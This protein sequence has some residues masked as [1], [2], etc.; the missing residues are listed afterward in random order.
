MRTFELWFD[1]SGRFLD[2]GHHEEDE[3][4]LVGLLFNTKAIDEDRAKAMLSRAFKDAGKEFPDRPHATSLRGDE[5]STI[6]A[7]LLPDLDGRAQPVR[8]TNEQK[9]SLG[10]RELTY[11]GFMRELVARVADS[12]LEEH[13]PV[14]L[15]VFPARLML[16][17]GAPDV[18]HQLSEKDYRRQLISEMKTQIAR[19][20][21]ADKGL[22]LKVELKSART[23]PILWLADFLSNASFRDFRKL[24]A[25]VSE[26]LKRAFGRWDLTFS[27]RPLLKR[28]DDL[29]RDHS[30]G[31]AVVESLTALE[32]PAIGKALKG[33]VAKK[34]DACAQALCALPIP[35]RQAHFLALNS[36]LTTLVSVER[37]LDIAG[38]ALRQ[39]EEHVIAPMRASSPVRQMHFIHRQEL[40]LLW[41]MLTHANHSADIEFADTVVQRLDESLRHVARHWDETN[42]VFEAL[43]AKAVHLVD[44]FE[45]ERAIMLSADVASATRGLASLLHDAMPAIFPETT[46]SD[47]EGKAIGTQLQ[48]LMYRGLLERE[49]LDYARELSDTAIAAFESPSDVERQWQYRSQLEAYAGDLDAARAALARGLALSPDAT[50]ADIVE[51]VISLEGFAQGFGCLH[52][53]RVLSGAARADPRQTETFL[54]RLAE[55]SWFGHDELPYPAHGIR[56]FWATTMAATGNVSRTREALNRL[57]ELCKAS[58]T[59]RLFLLIRQAAVAGAAAE[60][61]GHGVD[62]AKALLKRFRSDEIESALES[63]RFPGIKDRADAIRLAMEQG[64]PEALRAAARQVG[65]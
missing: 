61:Y 48:A 51:T 7:S 49:Y 55:L 30:Y 20:G 25:G 38:S 44:V 10:S 11:L 2:A 53:M 16:E 59:P 5:L 34:L 1:E 58:S 31:L 43:I 22:D 3:S 52:L 63:T 9:M 47:L 35:H 15:K 46:R 42:L 26:S 32:Q 12:L 36:W 13:G 56:R 28:L 50:L 41:H 6:I 17:D 23:N 33:E 54:M 37:D 45:H 40:E 4:Q 19:R 21:L 62:E 8:L 18:L 24:E 27:E 39:L 29:L 14:R 57:D 60:L 64:E 65:Y